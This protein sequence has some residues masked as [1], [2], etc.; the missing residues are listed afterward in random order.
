M[1]D[2]QIIRS[3]LIEDRASKFMGFY[4]SHVAA[5]E[6]QVLPEIKSA[7]HRIAA[8]RKPSTQRSLKST[9]LIE[10]G[11]DDDGEKYGG[12]AIEKVMEAMEVQGTVVVAR[13]YG[14][15]LLGPVRFDHIRN[16]AKEAISNGLRA[17][18]ETSRKKKLQSE[19]EQKAELEKILRERDERITVLR[20]LLAEKNQ[21]TSS[22]QSQAG[23][24][25]KVPD[26]SKQPLAVLK[27]LEEVRDATISWILKKIEEAEEQVE[28]NYEV[29]V[30]RKGQD[31][32]SKE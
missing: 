14:G 20:K 30:I 12:K 10:S 6:L 29:T 18:D 1:P 16:C 17:E 2:P 8:W 23:S 5:K 31:E 26:Y 24:P 9:P 21:Q 27:R 32:D 3:A 11:H 7:T 13:W 19:G 4:S 28:I 25:A 22:Q 15:V